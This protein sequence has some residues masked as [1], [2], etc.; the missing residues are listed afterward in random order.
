MKL[1][2]F[3]FLFTSKNPPGLN[4]LFPVSQTSFLW[5]FLLH[6]LCCLCFWLYIFNHLSLLPLYGYRYYWFIHQ[7]L[8]GGDFIRFVLFFQFYDLSIHTPCLFI[9]CSLCF[10][11]KSLQKLFT[12]NKLL[13]F[14]YKH[15]LYFYLI[16]I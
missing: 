6:V 1:H 8:W 12:L 9:T 4:H 11:M 15:L 14:F 5:S 3:C 10:I 16:L 2:G 7:A 13:T